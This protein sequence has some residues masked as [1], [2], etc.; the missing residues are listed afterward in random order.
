MNRI[1]RLFGPGILFASAA[2]GVS[3]LVQST[4]AGAEYGYSLIIFV[5]LTN[6]LKYPFFEFGSRYAL[7]NG[8]SLIAA[9]HRKSKYFLYLY[10]FISLISMF[11]VTAAV[12]Y[13]SAAIINSLFDLPISTEYTS[14]FLLLLFAIVFRKDSFTKLQKIINPLA[15]ILFFS[16]L[17]VFVLSCFKL[18][19]SELLINEMKGSVW[20]SE[21]LIF[22][23]ALMGW[24]PTAVDLSTWNSL[25]TVERLK[26]DKEFKKRVLKEFNQGYLISAILSVVF[27]LLGA[28]TLGGQ[29]SA[30]LSNIDFTNQFL[31]IYTSTLGSW[32]YYIV[33]LS[34]ISIML[35]TCFT[36]FDGYSRA[37]HEAMKLSGLKKVSSKRIWH[38]TLSVVSALVVLFLTSS[39]RQLIEIATITSFLIAP[40]IAFLNFKLVHA[41]DFE[42]QPNKFLSILSIIGLIYLL[43]FSLIYLLSLYI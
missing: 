18:D 14:L 12:T 36:V 41:N 5:V 30:G 9:Y 28:W 27:L 10:I 24:M 8:E 22:I 42:L 25:W 37:M 32:S 1:Q 34:A 35:S 20:D 15:L 38:W 40:I 7:A 16:T 6:L 2:I 29:D 26:T 13:V 19:F 17:L 23:I 11:T 33:G 39:L 31:S 21:N 4:R 3:H 43:A